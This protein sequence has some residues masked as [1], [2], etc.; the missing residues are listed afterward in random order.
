M[1]L[2]PQARMQFRRFRSLKRGY[3]SFLILSFLSALALLVEL[4][5]GNRALLVHY[6]G[7]LHIPVYGS[8]HPG[9]DFGLDYAYETDYRALKDRFSKEGRGNWVMMPIVP[10][11]P[12]EN[13]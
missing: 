1:R 8:I 10:Y 11:G 4:F 2:S 13:C 7:H 12:N 3:G 6:D 9:T 5:V